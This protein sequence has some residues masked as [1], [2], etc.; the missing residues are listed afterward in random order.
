MKKASM[1]VLV[2]MLAL[3]ALPLVGHAQV[4]E[5]CVATIAAPCTVT[6]GPADG[7]NVFGLVALDGKVSWIGVGDW[8]VEISD[9]AGN[10]TKSYSSATDNNVGPVAGAWNGAGY[11]TRCATAT[12]LTPGS[13]VAIGAVWSPSAP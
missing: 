3:V 5:G 9:C 4:P 10:V 8:T 1:A 13:A 2:A 12:A 6:A 7:T 11:Y